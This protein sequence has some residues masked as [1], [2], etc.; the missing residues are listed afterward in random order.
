[1]DDLLDTYLLIAIF[2]G[3]LAIGICIYATIIID[4]RRTNSNTYTELV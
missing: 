1:M 4:I 2:V 3:L